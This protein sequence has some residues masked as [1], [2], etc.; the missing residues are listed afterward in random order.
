MIGCG[1][2]L[3]FRGCAEHTYLTVEQFE[4]GV[5]P[6]NHEDPELA[7]TPFVDIT[8]VNN[9]DKT[10]KLSI[11]NSYARATE[12]MRLPV[13]HDDPDNLGASILRYLTKLSPGQ[14]RFYCKVAS[15]PH[16]VALAQQGY[17]RAEFFAN[18]PL[19]ENTVRKMMVEAAKF[20]G[21]PDDFRGH[22]LRHACLSDLANDPGVSLAETMKVARH[23]SAAAAKN[24]QRVDGISEGNRFRALGMLPKKRKD[25]PV[26]SKKDPEPP[27]PS[28]ATSSLKEA[29]VTPSTFA[30]F[31]SSGQQKTIV[32]EGLKYPVIDGRGELTKEDIYRIENMK[33]RTLGRVEGDYEYID[34]DS[35]NDEMDKKPAA[36]DDG[37]DAEKGWSPADND[38]PSSSDGSSLIQLGGR[39]SD[40]GMTQNGIDM[41]QKQVDDVRE[42]IAERKRPGLSQNQVRL[43][44]LKSELDS[45]RKQL[46]DRESDEELYYDSLEHDFDMDRRSLMNELERER[47]NARNLK[48][49]RDQLKRML[50]R[51]LRAKSDRKFNRSSYR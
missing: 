45:L 33:E 10:Q 37:Y 9:S 43:R 51:N 27:V 14:K 29:P 28:V 4:E 19:G 7:G 16:K 20:L 11:Y 46:K 36:K 40:G 21:L 26:L 38:S 23:S 42:I 32:T 8:F 15:A 39:I 34:S 12:T 22:S 24:Y 3:A 31:A 13:N 18:R 6:T 1:R 30:S 17:P 5:Y 25:P 49:E 44:E 47:R 35:D 2:Y 41:L 48:S 50:Q